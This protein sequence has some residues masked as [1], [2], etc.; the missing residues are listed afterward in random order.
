MLQVAEKSPRRVRGRTNA[1]QAVQDE[2]DE[3]DEERV[4]LR[5]S[6]VSPGK[7]RAR[8]EA[9]VER[10][11]GE[12]NLRVNRQLESE[13]SSLQQGSPSLAAP[14]D[15]NQNAFSSMPLA[16]MLRGEERHRSPDIVTP[17]QPRTVRHMPPQ[18]AKTNR[19]FVSRAKGRK[20]NSPPQDDRQRRLLE[21]HHFRNAMAKL[22]ALIGGG[23]R[24]R[25]AKEAL[26]REKEEEQSVVEVVHV[27]EEAK[28]EK[29]SEKEKIEEEEEDVG[30][31]WSSSEEEEEGEEEEVEEKVVKDRREERP[32]LSEAERKRQEKSHFREA[33]AL[34][35]KK[36]PR[37]EKPAP[38]PEPQ[39]VEPEPKAATAEAVVQESVYQIGRRML[40][41]RNA[42][43]GREKESAE[44]EAFVN[45]LLSEKRSGACYISGPS[46]V[47]KS[48]T[49]SGVTAKV[50][51][52]KQ[53]RHV[54]T[55]NLASERI[56][57]LMTHVAEL[58]APKKL[59]ERYERIAPF[60][61]ARSVVEKVCRARPVL[62]VLE[63]VD[64]K[65]HLKAVCEL[66]SIASKVEGSMLVLIGIGN[67]RSF[68]AKNKIAVSKLMT[69]ASY[70]AEDLIRI[71]TEKLSPEVC[72]QLVEPNALKLWAGK[73]A[74][75]MGDL[76]SATSCMIKAID[77]AEAE[78]L[79]KQPAP[80]APIKV[81]L[82][83]MKTLLDGWG[84]T[85][86]TLSNISGLA[87][88]ARI[89]L[90][91]LAKDSAKSQGQFTE[92]D[93][94]RVYC[95]LFHADRPE[96]GVLRGLLGSLLDTPFVVADNN[97]NV[98][99]YC[100]KLDQAIVAQ[101]I[102]SDAALTAFVK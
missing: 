35:E 85:K 90:I 67:K 62:L 43:I 97:G 23:K 94:R 86:D 54:V 60:A 9:V 100:V 21:K 11:G 73:V 101:A 92:A 70:S 74:E 15:E 75:H 102:A 69:F 12:K 1:K 30:S 27:V 22:E 39:V 95:D 56:G 29:Q 24:A 68:V 88:S 45:G 17:L 44:I 82:R 76:R 47:G 57:C 25:L 77:I 89:L 4:T 98:G 34:L 7:K 48:L 6:A 58:L 8:S 51:A 66:F 36:K 32:L 31:G 93:M 19:V 5:I 42:L 81:G 84:S 16:E 99:K 78:Y 87:P 49:V 41:G 14:Q 64:Q 72:S 28:T 96:Q 46:G 38:P 37:K 10:G 3:D 65:S 83:A 18:R 26:S 63:E 71:V 50:A 13:Q 59:S 20:P 80:A 55:V 52:S 33:M 53:S 91:G 61:H 79:S 2:E 40:Q